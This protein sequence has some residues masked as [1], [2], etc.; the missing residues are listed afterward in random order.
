MRSNVSRIESDLH[1]ALVAGESIDNSV[2]IDLMYE[3]S[4]I[5]WTIAH[6]AALR[7]H[8]DVLRLLHSLGLDLNVRTAQN[9]T[10]LQIASQKDKLAATAFLVNHGADMNMLDGTEHTAL[11]IAQYHK[12]AMAELM[13]RDALQR[14]CWKGAIEKEHSAS[15][16]ASPIRVH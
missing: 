16:P 10:P 15:P 3:K 1:K 8:V 9:S 6:Y 13:L 11:E 7:D 12:A 14:K 2:L 5:G 4:C